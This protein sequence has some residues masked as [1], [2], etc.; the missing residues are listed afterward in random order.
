MSKFMNISGKRIDL[1][2]VDVS[3]LNDIHEY[4]TMPEFFS[5]FEYDSFK[6][7]NQTKKFLEN[8]IDSESDNFHAWFIQLKDGKIIGTFVLRD[9]NF[10]RSSC[11]I[12]YGI[13][14]K[15]WEMGY[16]QETLKLIKNYLFEKLKFHRISAKVHVE[17]SKSINGLKKMGFKYEGKLK[18]F[19]CDKDGKRSDVVLLGIL[20]KK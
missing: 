3:G 1:V 8:L 15:Y 10:K 16:F 7:K 14:P 6:T 19:L 5:Y 20:N 13:S 18:D 11:E 17:N 9:V 4:S 2:K 12:T